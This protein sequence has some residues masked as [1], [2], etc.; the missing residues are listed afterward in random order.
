MNRQSGYKGSMYRGLI[1]KL[2][3]KFT[4]CTCVSSG[5]SGNAEYLAD[6][7]NR[8]HRSKRKEEGRW[9]KGRGRVRALLRW[10]GGW[11]I[12]SAFFHE[13]CFMSFAVWT[14]Q[15]YIYLVPSHYVLQLPQHRADQ[16][17]YTPPM[18]PFPHFPRPC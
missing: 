9:G 10:G 6:T 14:A 3:N 2:E 8:I 15:D 5:M 4:V 12:A 7:N 13:A 16:F 1:Y 18:S 17:I 11:S